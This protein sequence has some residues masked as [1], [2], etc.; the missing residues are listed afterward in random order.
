MSL[1]CEVVVCRLELLGVKVEEPA[2]KTNLLDG[3]RL[4]KTFRYFRYE[5]VIST[6]AG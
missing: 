2:D 6:P 3:E 1:F 4:I 5:T